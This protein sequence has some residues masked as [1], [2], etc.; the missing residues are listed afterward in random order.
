MVM[1]SSW[2]S[3]GEAARDVD[4][5]ALSDVVKDLLVAAFVTDEQEPQAVVAHHFQR[6]A[7]HVGLGV[8]R[9]GDA[10][11]AQFARDRLGA[12]PVV[13]EGVVVEEELPHLRERR[14]SP[15]GFRR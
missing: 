8:A 14:L 7:R 15:S 5:H 2:Q 3:L 9:P 4:A 13:R 11:L 6:I 1:P 10:Q 12:R